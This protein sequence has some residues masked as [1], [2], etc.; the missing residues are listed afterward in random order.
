MRL[1]E[2][3]TH[4]AIHAVMRWDMSLFPLLALHHVRWNKK[5]PSINQAVGP[6]PGLL[7]CRQTLYP[8]SHQGSRLIINTMWMHSDRPIQGHWKESVFS[9]SLIYLQRSLVNAKFPSILL[10]YDEISW[11]Y[12]MNQLFQREK[13]L[14]WQWF[15][16]LNLWVAWT[17]K[18]MH[19]RVSALDTCRLESL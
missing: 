3:T 8:L 16:V 13:G 6:R 2:W 5:M 12:K 18:C 7:H 11:H 17:Q 19:K 1:W 9:L 10:T 14:L 15:M 4:N